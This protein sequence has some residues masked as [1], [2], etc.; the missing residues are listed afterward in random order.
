MIEQGKTGLDRSILTGTTGAASLMDSFL[1]QPGLYLHIPFCSSICPFCPYNKVLYQAELVKHYFNA[2]NQELDWYLSNGQLPFTSLY[3]GGGSPSLCLT[4]LKQ[5][6]E[7]IPIDGE[8]A[9]E[10]LPNH[11]S[12]ETVELLCDMG[13]NYISLGIQ[14]FNKSML[15][16][17]GRPNTVA[18]NQRA[19]ENTLGQFECVDIDLIFDVAFQDESVFLKDIETCFE[20]GVDQVSTYP[21]MRFGYTPFGKARHQSGKEHTILRKA[22]E[23]ASRF[24]YER[25]SVWTF[26]KQ[27]SANYTSIT[28]EFYLGLGAGAGSF[29]GHQFLLNHFSISRY[30][31]SIIEHGQL[32]IARI[33]QLSPLRS[34]LYYLFWQAYTGSIDLARFETFFPGKRHLRWLLIV[35]QRSGY[36][37]LSENRLSLTRR[38]YNRYHNLERWITYHFIEPLWNEM[39]HE[40]QH[41]KDVLPPIGVSDRLWLKISGVE[42]IK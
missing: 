42:K 13:I 16:H 19:L 7:K 25:R 4:Q 41:L 5:I 20:A 18:D 6:L 14:S 40:H 30:I 12:N 1:S 35:L 22:E 9:I 29:T 15:Q 27:G 28:R 23:I 38:G 11:A 26:N 34:A 17:L 24:G 8:R 36:L 33:S 32:P 37:R 21:L 10:L 31:Q 39:M 3:I 2:L